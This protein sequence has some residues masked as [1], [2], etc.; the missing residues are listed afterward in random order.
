MATLRRTLLWSLLAA[1]LWTLAGAK[2]QEQPAPKPPPEP[3]QPAD[4]IAFWKGLWVQQDSGGVM[5][6]RAD[7]T[8]LG[9]PVSGSYTFPEAGWVH[10]T[11]G[12]EVLKCRWKRRTDDIIDLARFHEG[13]PDTVQ[14]LRLKPAPLDLAKWNGKCV[15]RH[16]QAG[17]NTATNRSVLVDPATGHFRTSE[18]GFYLRLLTA[19]NGGVLAYAPGLQS[20]TTNVTLFAAD[21]HLVFFDRLEKPALFASCL[22]VELPDPPPAKK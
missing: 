9:L 5:E 2:A 4:P 20:E 10:I 13:I 15:I 14:L 6:F 12:P 18:G 17:T 16:M 1:G 3:E 11:S 22:F 8:I 19:P 21:K 7:G